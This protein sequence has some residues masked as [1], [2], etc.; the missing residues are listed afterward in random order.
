MTYFQE[1]GQFIAQGTKAGLDLPTI[2]K[3]L[4]YATTLQ[5]LAVAQCNGDYPADNGVRKVVFCPRCE[6]G[7]L[8]SVFKRANDGSKICPDCR[9]QELVKAVLPPNVTPIFGG[10]PRGAVLKLATPLHPYSDDGQQGY[11]LYVPAR[12]TR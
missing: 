12:E 7:F 3:L 6:A 11:G 2:T 8:P 5:R 1:V 4:R 10:D 9:T